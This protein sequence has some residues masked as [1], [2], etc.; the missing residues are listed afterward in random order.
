[1]AFYDLS[2]IPSQYLFLQHSTRAC[3]GLERE[4]LLMSISSLVSVSDDSDIPKTSDGYGQF[5][6]WIF[7]LWR[8][9]FKLEIIFDFLMVRHI[10]W[11]EYPYYKYFV[12]PARTIK[13]KTF[14]GNSI[15]NEIP[16]I[17]LK[18]MTLQM[19]LRHQKLQRHRLK[20]LHFIT[21]GHSRFAQGFIE[22]LARIFFRTCLTEKN[23]RQKHSTR[24]FKSN[25][26]TKRTSWRSTFYLFSLCHLPV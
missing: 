15:I 16:D 25:T 1:M 19:E 2:L 21:W 10:L 7:Y 9:I 11:N 3:D 18:M 23:I 20:T 12:T 24:E 26:S 5:K 8:N 22:L 17:M 6:R 4:C 14:I 13:I